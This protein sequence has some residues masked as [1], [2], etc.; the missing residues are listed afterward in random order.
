VCVV[1]RSTSVGYYTE[2]KKMYFMK[3]IRKG[4]NAYV[5]IML[6]LRNIQNVCEN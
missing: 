2:Y 5:A 1:S 6:R 4:R 3:N